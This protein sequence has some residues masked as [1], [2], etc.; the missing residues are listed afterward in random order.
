MLF[1]MRVPGGACWIFH[2]D[3]SY[4]YLCQK[5]LIHAFCLDCEIR[6]VWRAGSRYQRDR[7]LSIYGEDGGELLVHDLC[8]VSGL[9]VKDAILQQGGDTVTILASGFDVVPEG[10]GIPLIQCLLHLAA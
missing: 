9:V 7:V 8:F 10:F 3:F 4:Y 1:R 2:P 6:D 5:C